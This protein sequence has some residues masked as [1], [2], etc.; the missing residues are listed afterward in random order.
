MFKRK[1]LALMASILVLFTVSACAGGDDPAAMDKSNNKQ[2]SVSQES[3]QNKKVEADTDK[4]QDDFKLKDGETFLDHPEQL[5]DMVSSFGQIVLN[6]MGLSQY[7]LWLKP[8]NV[9][10]S[11]ESAKLFTM[12]GSFDYANMF[13]FKDIPKPIREGNKII[14]T[15]NGWPVTDLYEPNETNLETGKRIYDLFKQAQKDGLWKEPV[16]EAKF[17][18]ILNDDGKTGQLVLENITLKK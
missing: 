17:I 4:S 16:Q 5:T 18:F 10:V 15:A 7:N 2:S 6:E 12:Q 14:F 9:K 11:D 3:E 13:V 8:L 1:V